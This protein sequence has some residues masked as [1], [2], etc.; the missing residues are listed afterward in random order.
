M[1][2]K[3]A[4]L[5]DGS[6]FCYRAY[7]ALPPLSNS[8]GMPTGAIYGFMSMLNKIIKEERPDYLAISFD[9]GFPTF[10]HKAYEEYKIER[11][12]MPDDL[13]LQMDK[14]R[15]VIN[16]YRIPVYEHK[17]FEADDVLATLSSQL[18]KKG[19]E[20]YIVTHDKDMFQLV[21]DD[22]KVYA[23]NKE[24]TVYDAGKVKEK[25]G[26]SPERVL[27]L[28]ALTGDDIDNIPG[29]KG[30][31]EKTASMLLEEFGSVEG[32]LNNSDKIKKPRVKELIE[33]SKKEIELSLKLARLAVD[34]P[35]KAGLDEME[36]KEPDKRAL[37]ELF[38]ELEFKTLLKDV[39]P[40]E[41]EQNGRDLA[42]PAL[43]FNG[44]VFEFLRGGGSLPERGLSILHEGKADFID[45]DK[46]KSLKAVFEDEKV[47]KLTYD[48]KRAKVLLF[49][50][51]GIEI[52][53]PQFDVMLASYVLNPQRTSHLLED[54]TVEYLDRTVPENRGEPSRLRAIVELEK[55]FR[56]EL[57]KKKAE[58]LFYDIEM[59]LT[60]VLASMEV[61]GVYIDEAYLT[62]L[63]KELD[64]KLKRLTKEIFEISG[65]EFNINSPK[66]L[67]EV[68]FERLKLKPVK[69]TKTGYST[70]S[71][72]L[73]ELSHVHALPKVLLEFRALAKLKSTYVDALPSLIDPKDK[74]LHTSF[75]Q[76]VTQTGRLSSSDPNLQNIPIK[77]D[78]GKKIRRAFSAQGSSLL[79]LIADYSQIELRILAHLSGDGNLVKAFKDKEDVHSYTASLIFKV[80]RENVT[81]QMRAMAKTVNFGIIYGMS[82]YGLSRELGI[83]VGEAE[84]FIDSYFNR[85]PDVKG[86]LNSQI[87]K[88]RK[89]GHVSTLF[90]RRRYI[91]EINSPNQTVR[92]FAERTAIN[93]PIQGTA[94]DIIKLAMI[95]VHKAIKEKGLAADMILQVHDELIFEFDAKVEK[96][97]RDLV[98]GEMEGV[99]VLQVP[100]VVDIAVGKNWLEAA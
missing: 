38:R 64:E 16:A 19:I 59:P 52:K 47:E 11:K 41:Q 69:R 7:Y 94:S 25:L 63:S 75:N 42:E 61:K 56:R 66:Q 29:V 62:Q 97:L 50:E 10:R 3:R 58:K 90:D 87:E 91:P 81:P 15:E 20:V 85:Y 5:I 74:R 57:P 31:G 71:G 13:K 73:E 51:S 92:Q 30:I 53:G 9:L 55:L 8:K 44:I 89:E 78:E 70:D 17:G 93:A 12:P 49:K 34:V 82:G 39:A 18:K 22:I 2:K 100:L 67:S 65:C 98:K 76:A 95:N 96:P 40:A 68:L 99:A 79:L 28:M 21:T 88:A 80:K 54:I 36:L 83:G 72:V 26:V 27:D 32:V 48:I 1:K 6:S 37:F 84:I 24:V 43:R 33:S 35:L 4:F 45:E 14:L 86:Y 46:L 23:P 60:D 77:T